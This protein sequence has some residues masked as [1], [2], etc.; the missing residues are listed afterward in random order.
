[1]SYLL[2]AFGWIVRVEAD[3]DREAAEKLIAAANRNARHA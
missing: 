3:S 2:D 1:M